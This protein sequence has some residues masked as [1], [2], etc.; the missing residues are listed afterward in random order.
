MVKGKYITC[1]KPATSEYLVYKKGYVTTNKYCSVH[2]PK[3]Q[4][5]LQHMQLTGGK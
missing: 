3:E 5:N 1:C 4:Y 2:Q